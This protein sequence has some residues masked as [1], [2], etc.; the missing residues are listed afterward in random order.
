MHRISWLCNN[1]DNGLGRKEGIL[2]RKV[3]LLVGGWW[4]SWKIP[5]AN[6]ALSMV[7]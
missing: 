6:K 7:D 1:G 3:A 4:C 5:R 2:R